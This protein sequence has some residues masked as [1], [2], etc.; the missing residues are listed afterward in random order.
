MDGYPIQPSATGCR[1]YT[2][3][4]LQEKIKWV[5]LTVGF[6]YPSAFPSREG[7]EVRGG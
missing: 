3:N 7:A 5:T 6:R 4:M 1:T 2:Q